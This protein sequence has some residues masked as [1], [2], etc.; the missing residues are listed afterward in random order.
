MDIPGTLI[1]AGVLIISFILIFAIGVSETTP[2]FAR[3]DFDNI[4]NKYLSLMIAKGGLDS[5][6]KANLE[7]EL[8]SI[9]YKN[10]TITAP[11]SAE[12]GSEITLK[13]EAYYDYDTINPDYTRENKSVKSTYENSTRY[14]G[15]EN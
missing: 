5:T 11:V 12:W 13:V 6:D 10:V 14:F 15:L 2:T 1:I 4:C 7:N 3:N 9:G 8:M